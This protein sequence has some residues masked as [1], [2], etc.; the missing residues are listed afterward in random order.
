[1]NFD[2]TSLYL[3]P[4][5]AVSTFAAQPGTTASI[6]IT[7]GS[8]GTNWTV[9]SITSSNQT[10]LPD[11]GLTVNSGKTAIQRGG[12]AEPDGDTATITMTLTPTNSGMFASPIV[13]TVVLN[14]LP[15][16]SG[17]RE[18]E[19]RDDSGG[20]GC[21]GSDAGGYFFERESDA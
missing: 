2:D 15:A 21:D 10:L 14:V 1:M 9:S 4:G 12:S 7:Q 13:S 11:S 3:T 17:E 18:L 19:R 6:P 5:A 16:V 8:L 20:A